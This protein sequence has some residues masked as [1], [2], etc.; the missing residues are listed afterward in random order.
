M[1]IT[2]VRDRWDV[3]DGDLPPVDLSWYLAPDPCTSPSTVDVDWVKVDRVVAQVNAIECN[4]REVLALAS[5][6]ETDAALAPDRRRLHAAYKALT[7]DERRAL[8]RLL[9]Q[10]YRL[11]PG[12]LARHLNVHLLDIRVFLADTLVE[13]EKL[14]TQRRG[15]TP[16]V[17]VMAARP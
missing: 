7:G 16:R 1:T 10:R 5:A 9:H 2:A 8:V 13:Q 4:L 15:G 11:T 6:A 3:D 12:I 17:R 14:R